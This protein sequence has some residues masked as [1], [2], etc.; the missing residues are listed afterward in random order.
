M[1]ESRPTDLLLSLG[2]SRESLAKLDVYVEI[3]TQWQTSINLVG[4]STLDAIW[5]RHVVDAAQLM[6]LFSS[7]DRRLADLG[8]GA[9]IPGLVLA[10][11]GSYEVDLYESNGKKAAFLREAIRRTGAK[12]SVH[13]VRLETLPTLITWPRVDCVVARAL[14]PLKQLLEFAEPFLSTG[15]KAFFHKG[16]DIDVELTEATKY[17]KLNT[18]KH[19]SITDSRGVIIEIRKAVRG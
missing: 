15:A 11:A 13:Q 3:L 16:Q 7:E 1:Q 17:W 5:I 14:A 6:P 4:S 12:A 19:Q 8:S 9:G 2:V 10:I 18:I